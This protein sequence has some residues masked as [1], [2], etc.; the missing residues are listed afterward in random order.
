[1]AISTGIQI[2]LII[3]LILFIGGLVTF[4]VVAN[5]SKKT[6]K[7]PKQPKHPK[8]KPKP[9]SNW[10]DTHNLTSGPGVNSLECPSL[11]LGMYNAWLRAPQTIKD[12][13]DGHPN[14]RK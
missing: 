12:Q 2:G 1:M 3:L 9:V 5:K 8:P 10:C 6:G 11:A 7:S 4:F 13:K 14:K